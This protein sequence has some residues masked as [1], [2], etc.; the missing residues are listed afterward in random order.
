MIQYC[1]LYSGST[2][3][4]T[5]IGSAAGGI[6]VDAGVSAKRIEQALAQR[7]I[8]PHSIRAL[9]VSHEHSD[10]IAGLPVLCKRYG[11]PVLASAGTLDALAEKEKVLPSQRLYAL[12]SGT[13][14]AVDDIQVTPFAVPHDSRA[15]LGFRMDDGQGHAVALATDMGRML[16]SVLSVLTGCQ[17][18]HIESNHDPE[19]LRNGPYPYP[20]QQRILGDG[21]HLCNEAC[22]AVLPHLVDSGAVRIVL[23]HLSQHNNTPALA[24]KTA[25]AALQAAEMTVGKDFYLQVAAPVGAGA[26]QTVGE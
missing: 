19:M 2:G 9:F 4:C 8:D 13:P 14:V 24:E 16:P 12:Q 5:Y 21:G 10:H 20:L 26:V 22:A 1:S 23:A 25:L 15:C 3:N 11:W 18:I 7:Q 17:L 6:L